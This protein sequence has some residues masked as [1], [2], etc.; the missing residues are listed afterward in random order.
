MSRT[1]PVNLPD[2]APHLYEFG[3]FLL[4]PG[5]HLLRKGEECIPLTPKTFDT[6]VLLVAN[7]GRMLPKEELM[8]KLWPDSFVEESNLTQQISMVR[9]ALGETAGEA[10]FIV[11][12]PGRG[13]RFGAPVTARFAV[14]A[15]KTE[16]P[17]AVAPMPMAH[18]EARPPDSSQQAVSELIE[19]T[20][21]VRESVKRESPAWWQRWWAVAAAILL[22]CAAGVALFHARK[23][24]SSAVARKAVP[25]LAILPFHNLQPNA[26]DDFLGFSLADAVIS[27]LG[28]VSGLSVR[29]SSSVEKYRDRAVDVKKAAEE[30]GVE[31]VL[32][33]NFIR[34][35]DRLRITPQL[36]DVKND[37][38]L[39]RDTL[40][41]KYENLLK[42]QDEFSKQIVHGLALN[43]TSAETQRLQANG[44]VVPMAY[45]YYLRGTDL[46]S[47]NDFPTA[48]KMLEKSADLDP[49]YALTW[50]HL[51]KAYQAN[52]SFNFG[53][54]NQYRSAQAAYER[55]LA[56]DPNQIEARI[57]MSNLFTDTG[58]VEEAVPI[59]RKAMEINPNHP[60]LHWELGYAYRFGGMLHESVAEAE[61]A[62]QLDPWVKRNSSA[63][64]GY[65]YLGQYDKFLST[66][67]EATGVAYLAFYRGF[68]EYLRGNT[69]A[70]SEEF[71][72]AY[73]LDPQ[74]MQA[75][76][77]KA[78]RFAI[79][80]QNEKGIALL[81][82]AEKM[83]QERDVRDSEALYKVAQAYAVLGDADSA[84]RVLERSVTNGF[85]AYPYQ[86]N[87]PLL[88]S[89]KGRPE[90]ARILEGSRARHEAFRGKFFG[91][92]AAL[93]QQ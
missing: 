91:S 89:L 61:L 58:R 69:Q 71:D 10:R 23:P 1:I 70:A 25:T 13:Y 21:A 34:E 45:E 41:M 17:S 50:A 16:Q 3:P 93:K 20:P 9:K 2:Q 55:A 59:L 88:A 86:V 74:L 47:R 57:F 12:V 63:I 78:L 90:F 7:Q 66:L 44:P 22:V 80:R 39:W 76:V 4:D 53:G 83:V 19:S 92:G 64:N 27:K 56:L 62:R 37:R 79:A 51:G 38:I 15:P 36:V 75:Q 35:A 18:A 30:L 43:L 42:V 67:P 81:R 49:T 60:E 82:G 31:T 54:E 77:G 72:L 6:L 24:A 48:I 40:D 84:L 65:L 5:Q 26:E 29:P 11:T 28:Y 73:D 32:T 87:D 14:A 68:A 52:A 8:R 33:G 85:F 46:Y